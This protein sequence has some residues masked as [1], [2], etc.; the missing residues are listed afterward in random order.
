MEKVRPWCGQLYDRGR[1][2]NRIGVG[3]KCDACLRQPDNQRTFV[4]DA[5][6]VRP[7]QTFALLRVHLGLLQS[8]SPILHFPVTPACGSRSVT[9]CLHFT[10]RLYNRL[11]NLLYNRLAVLCK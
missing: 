11:Y 3:Y 10:G 6:T 8:S 7:R 9:R 2:K 4:V 1:L 5:G